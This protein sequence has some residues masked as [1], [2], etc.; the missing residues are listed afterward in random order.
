MKMSGLVEER[1]DIF[2]CTQFFL[3]SLL[4]AACFVRT[5]N[6]NVHASLF[7]SAVIFFTKFYFGEKENITLNRLMQL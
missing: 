7:S 6:P 5:R 3:F 4:S 2:P 1:V